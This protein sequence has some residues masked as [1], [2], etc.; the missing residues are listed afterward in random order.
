MTAPNRLTEP[1][2]E[3]LVRL[4]AD[5]RLGAWGPVVRAWAASRA[6]LACISAVEA[7]QRAGAVVYPQEVLHAL[8]LTPLESVRVLI[9]GQ[10]PY[11]GA[12]QAQGLAFS[13]PGGQRLPPSLRNI[14]QEVRRDTGSIQAQAAAGDLSAWARQGVLLLNAS[15][16][17]EDGQPA[18]HARLGWDGLIRAL[19]Q[20]VADHVSFPGP[21]ARPSPN[22]EDRSALATGGLAALLWGTHAQAWG[23]VLHAQI[24]A[25]RL[26]V[27]QS[28]HPSP[29]SARRPP[30]PFLGC[31]HF[32]R[33]RDFLAALDP[34]GP[35]LVW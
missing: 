28:N 3:H 30:A 12:G 10:D 9:L 8:V 17:V 5:G 7:R 13:V 11:H 19:L 31:G 22:I 35:P 1:L 20:A 14:L 26:L 23:P 15:L 6:G 24:P 2:G 18:S 27:L 29:L 34:G 16:T 4:V 25:E 33:A 32:S 21:V